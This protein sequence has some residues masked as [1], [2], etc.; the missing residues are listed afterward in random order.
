[1]PV[2]GRIKLVSCSDQWLDKD[3]AQNW[4]KFHQI[5]GMA[6]ILLMLQSDALAIEHHLLMSLQE[7][8][9]PRHPSKLVV[10]MAKAVPS[11]HIN[12]YTQTFNACYV[13]ASVTGFLRSC[14]LS[15]AF[16]AKRIAS[17][18]RGQ[19]HCLLRPGLCT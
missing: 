9:S 15:P 4:R 3:S 16:G 18:T 2:H 6:F 14:T 10:A 7:V 12:Q 19:A 8:L 11:S 1:M 17:Y 13:R 5:C